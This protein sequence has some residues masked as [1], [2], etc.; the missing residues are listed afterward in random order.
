MLSFDLG[1][2][3]RSY[4]EDLEYL[5]TSAGLPDPEDVATCIG[6]LDVLATFHE[7]GTSPSVFLDFPSVH[8]VLLGMLVH[9]SDLPLSQLASKVLE[10]L[11]PG[12]DDAELSAKLAV[13]ITKVAERN[14]YGVKSLG[15]VKNEDTSVQSH[16]R[17]NC[18]SISDMPKVVQGLVVSSRITLS[19][20]EKHVSAITKFLAMCEKDVVDESKLAA[21]GEG[22]EKRNRELRKIVEKESALLLKKVEDASKKRKREDASSVVKVSKVSCKKKSEPSVLRFFPASSLA[23]R[24]AQLS[25]SAVQEQ[26]CTSFFSGWETPSNS[27]MAPLRRRSISHEGVVRLDESVGTMVPVDVLSQVSTRRRSRGRVGGCSRKVK[28]LQFHENYRPAF[29]GRFTKVSRQ[30]CGRFP[31]REDPLLKYRVDSDDDWFCNEAAEEDVDCVGDGA[32]EDSDGDVLVVFRRVF[33][34][35]CAVDG[36]YCLCFNAYDDFLC[37]RR[38][39]R[40]R[41][42]TWSMVG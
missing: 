13:F 29:F 41:T 18:I 22:I 15:L 8:F 28:F 39:V 6:A 35:V 7:A 10:D 30:V 9:G 34:C 4:E 38:G 27:C 23:T 31:L 36:L 24:K 5:L 42:L 20:R 33:V 1:E 16:W 3:K 40:R 14:A 19:K 32:E 17:W 21:L 2:R 37:L 26:V 25:P 11:F 12:V